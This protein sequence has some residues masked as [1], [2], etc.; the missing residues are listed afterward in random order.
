MMI[1]QPFTVRS[2]AL[3]NRIV[4]PPMCMFSSDATGVAQDFHRL[5]YG[6]RAMGGT[7]LVIEE[8]TAVTPEGRISDRDLGIWDDA[9][10]PGLAELVRLIHGGGAAAGIQLAHAGRKSGSASRPLIGPSAV[11]FDEKSRVPK[12]MDA[13]DIARVVAAFRD[14]A[15][16]ALAAGF[17][18]VEVHAAHGYLLHG[19]LSPVSNQRADGYG[20]STENR[21][22]LLLE[23]LDAIRSV[24]PEDKP[25]QVRLSASDYLARGLDIEETIRIVHLIRDKADLFHISSGG[26]APAPIRAYPGYQTGF[27]E[28]VRT[29]CGV[30]TIAVGLITSLEQAEET[31]SAGRADLVALGRELL[32]D[33]YWP[34]RQKLR[35]PDLAIPVPEPYGRGF[36]I[37]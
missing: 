25:I 14:G 23:V 21:A 2:L 7:A 6:A 29:A 11:A 1:D 24:W 17:D 33:P 28:A 36:H 13:S 35:V 34:V 3:R 26:V 30:P 37:G 4:M 18:L 10:I 12:E 19:F 5:H 15:A 8:A 32:R 22:R 20:G 16:R 27:S 31:L 9:Q